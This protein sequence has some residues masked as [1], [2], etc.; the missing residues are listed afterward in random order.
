MTA[1]TP[2]VVEQGPVVYDWS[3]GANVSGRRAYLYDADTGEDL[4]GYICRVEFA[5]G[6]VVTEAGEEVGS[7]TIVR[8]R[9]TPDGKYDIDYPAGEVRTDTEDHR[10]RLVWCPS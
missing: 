7:A 5:A 9:R 6:R 8:L 4:G 1:D 10:V 2:I 3:S